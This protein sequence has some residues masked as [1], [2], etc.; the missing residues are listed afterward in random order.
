MAGKNQVPKDF[1]RVVVAA[2]VGNIIE[3]YDF[4]IFGSLAAILS[5][6]FFDKAHPV[7]AL[8]STIALFT[9][10]FLIRPLG[11]FL[12]G[13]LGD[14]VGRKYTFIVTLTGMGLATA[15]IGLIPTFASIG[16]AA[17][18]ILF[19]LRIDPGAVPGRGIRWRDH[20]CGRARFGRASGVLHRLAADVTD[21]GHRGVP[22]GDRWH[23]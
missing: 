22:R 12:F 8:L 2:A 17:A 4:Y 20:L 23:P 9:A 14:K 3:W 16:L 1:R 21:A 18:F 15:A 5:V 13:W 11:A 7:A 19:G 10:G 6:K